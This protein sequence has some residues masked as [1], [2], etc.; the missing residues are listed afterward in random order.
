MFSPIDN[1]EVCAGLRRCGRVILFLQ[2]DGLARWSEVLGDDA[3]LFCFLQASRG[4]EPAGRWLWVARRERASGEVEENPIGRSLSPWDRNCDRLFRLLS[5]QAT[6]DVFGRDR[7]QPYEV[8]H[9]YVRYGDAPGA[10]EYLEELE[11]LSRALRAI[12]EDAQ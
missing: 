7:L 2:G 8:L 12:G 10:V 3:Q 4:A 5:L 1:V 11:R 6:G 9:W